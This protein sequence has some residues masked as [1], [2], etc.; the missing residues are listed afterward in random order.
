MRISKDAASFISIS[1]WVLFFGLLFDELLKTKTT[2]QHERIAAAKHQYDGVE[3]IVE[4]SERHYEVAGLLSVLLIRGFSHT[5]MHCFNVWLLFSCFTPL[6]CG[7][8][9]E[10]GF[11]GES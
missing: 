3:T 10:Q 4:I 7:K 8:P 11:G 6:D 5:S 1:Q 2:K 9:T